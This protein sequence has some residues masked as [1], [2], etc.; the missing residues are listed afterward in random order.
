MLDHSAIAG[1]GARRSSAAL[2]ADRSLDLMSAATQFARGQEIFGEGEPV[3]YLYKV[4]SGCVRTYHTGNDGRRQIDSFYLP[5]D[6]FGLEAGDFYHVSADATVRSQ[7]RTIN[8][9]DFLSRGAGNIAMIGQLLD[10]TTVELQRTQAHILLLRKSAERRVVGFLLDMAK[11][12]DNPSEIVLP[13]TRQDIADYLGLTVETVSRTFTRLECASTISLTTIRHIVL[14][15]R[16]A[17]D[18]L[19]A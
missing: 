9:A 2:A 5:G 11:R 12:E 16:A 18:Q 14:H 6:I 1:N 19:N 4:K 8:K 7:V 17:L 15:N 13:M 10:L 3:H